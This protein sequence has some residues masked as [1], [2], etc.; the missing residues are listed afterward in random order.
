VATRHAVVR[1]AQGLHAR[2]AELVARLARQFE[3]TTTLCVGSQRV[4]AKSI[5]DV[6]TL[7]AA[8][9][10]KVQIETHGVDADQAGDELVRL[11][12]SD[13]LGSRG[14]SASGI[15]ASG[16]GASGIG[17]SGIGHSGNGQS[18]GMGGPDAPA[19]AVGA[20]IEGNS[21]QANNS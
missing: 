18:S 19:G 12:E 1:H 10:T 13:F 15:G 14:G 11:I 2:P 5:L 16:T 20:S 3:A 21:Q 8:V 6:L 7:G 4:D 9:G 17:A